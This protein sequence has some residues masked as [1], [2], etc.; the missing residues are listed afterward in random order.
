MLL[1]DKTC[2]L[3]NTHH[4]IQALYCCTRSA[5]AKIVQACAQQDLFIVAEVEYLELVLTGQGILCQ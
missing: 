1:S 5:L 3:V 2:R 4:D